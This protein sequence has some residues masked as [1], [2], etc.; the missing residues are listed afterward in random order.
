[1]LCVVIKGPTLEEVYQQLEKA[2]VHADLVELRLDYFQTLN[3]EALR[4]LRSHFSIPMIFT[5]RSQNQG[6]NYTG[7]E[8]AR[9][10]EIRRLI[11]LK[12]EYLDLEK[13]VSSLLITEIL[14]RSAETKL[15]LSYHDFIGTPD[16]L[17]N[18]YQE[19]KKI[20]AFFYKIATT[21]KNCLD[22]LRLM[23][24][25]Q[26]LDDKLIAISKGVHG[27]ISR[28]LGPIIQSPITYAALDE[29]KKTASGQL[30][31]DEILERYHHRVINSH[32][33]IYGLIGD[34]VDQSISDKTHNHLM[35]ACGF[36]AVYVKIQVLPSELK[37]FFYYVRQL[38][39]QG[40]SVTMPLKERVL[41][42][43]DEI[44]SQAR[45]I[46][47]VNTLHFVD[48]KICGYNT[49][50][51]GALNAIESECPVKGKKVVIIGAGGASKAIAFEA[52]KRGGG[53]TILNRDEKKAALIANHLHCIGK[54]LDEIS[55]CFEAGYDILINS[56][57]SCL[58]ISPNYI[59][60]QSIVMD[61]KTK[62]KETEFL[63]QAKAKNCIIIHGYRMFIEQ[64]VGQF[65]F[66]FANKFDIKN[67]RRILQEVS[68]FF[69]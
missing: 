63:K 29:E 38:P 5:L 49:D 64:A 41:P 16:D 9:L 14:S 10:S 8:E 56:T 58:P 40:L 57:P 15:I 43:L 36:E 24:W 19:M 44:D 12:P 37:D 39:F 46:G 7:S 6:G 54:S 53:V 22:A 65:H 17:D 48:G 69:L 55:S 31:V 62:P 21:A 13:D 26:K 23:C 1:M 66:W 52:H 33:A 18:I 20:P 42:F 3:R 11:E 50:G 61:I 67:G 32:T 27:Q 34:P 60:S 59:L 2:V 45:D 30:L 47:A 4:L 28:I 35:A 51:L 68:C 25:K